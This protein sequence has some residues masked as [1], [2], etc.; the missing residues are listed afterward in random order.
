[1]F[2]EFRNHIYGKKLDQA[3][4]IQFKN[5]TIIIIFYQI[6]VKVGVGQKWMQDFTMIYLE[7]LIEL[8]K[9]IESYLVML[10]NW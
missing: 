8:H 10:Q 6:L 9:I 5:V 3:I 2:V 1:M 4:K 7:Y